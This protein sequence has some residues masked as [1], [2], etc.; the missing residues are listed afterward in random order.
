M[1]SQRPR[2]R[3]ERGQA[4][5]MAL[6]FIAFF[7]LVTSAVLGFADTVARGHTAAETVAENDAL[8]NGGAIL[9]AVDARYSGGPCAT[10]GGGS[11]TMQS[12]DSVSFAIH[13]CDPGSGS[14]GSA[15]DS[16]AYQCTVCL[17]SNPVTGE[18]LQVNH[19]A[20]VQTD[21]PIAIGGTVTFNGPSG[22]VSSNSPLAMVGCVN[23]LVNCGPN[24]SR[25]SPAPTA[26]SAA[27]D[28]LSSI[29]LAQ[30][31]VPS[32][33]QGPCIPVV[34]PS[35][36]VPSDRC[37]SDITLNGPAS[38]S[39]QPGWYVITGQI[40]ID[41]QASLTSSGG[42]ILYFTCSG[43]GY[44][45]PCTGG[46]SAGG[47]LDEEG[48]G[49]TLNS[50]SGMPDNLVMFFDRRE[51]A[52]MVAPQN[53][54]CGN[55]SPTPVVCEAGNGISVGGTIYAASA[56]IDLQGTGTTTIGAGGSQGDLMVGDLIAAVGTGGQ[57]KVL[58]PINPAGGYCWVYDDYPVSGTQGSQAARGHAVVASGS[59]IGGAGVIN[60]NYGP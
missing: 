55:N 47:S 6:A 51:T 44:A 52:A 46:D 49:V 9:G 43:G 8:I 26:I 22:S 3:P 57:V 1:L 11:L 28:P 10:P 40:A 2:R 58:N 21:G 19:A 45:T 59:C 15:T 39:L 36:P 23:I 37:Y 32:S 17:L 31:G 5:L 35:G 7:G 56:T 27:P 50:M 4:L 24:S 54:D 18:A 34:D 14:F 38:Y 48:N 25:F 16:L 29:T 41:G 33:R 53:H 42:V 12:G 13:E 60:V 30:L 20:D